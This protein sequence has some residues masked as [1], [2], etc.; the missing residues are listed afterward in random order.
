MAIYRHVVSGP[1]PAGDVWSSTI[2]SA[3]SSTINGAHTGFK[4][5]VNAFLGTSMKPLW[6]TVLSA[7]RIE[8]NQIDPVTGRNLD[9]IIEAIN[10]VGTSAGNALPQRASVVVGM[11][12]TLPTR[13]G[14]GRMYIPAPSVTS[15]TTTGELKTADASLIVN[16]AASAIG[17]QA[18]LTS[19]GIW[20][21]GVGN[22]TPITQ[23]SVSAV[24]GT[25]RRRTNKV[26]PDYQTADV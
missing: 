14:R 19:F 20:H 23:C 7:T 12:T 17:A 5:F 25:Q 4:N 3:N 21:R 10:I 16:G 15:I 8:T 26:A 24:L 18:A 11:R 1:G 22:I 2:H 6:P 9:Q 13:A